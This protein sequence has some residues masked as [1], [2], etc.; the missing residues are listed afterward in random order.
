MGGPKVHEF[1][2]ERPRCVTPAGDLLAAGLHANQPDARVC[3]E[4]IEDAH[5]VAAAANAGDDCLR[6]PPRSFEDLPARLAPDDRLEVA[7]HQRIGMG[8]KRRSQQIV[9]A[10]HVG[11]PVAHRLVDGVLQRAAARIDANHLGAEEPHADNVQCLAGHVVDAHVDVAF[12]P[13]QRARRC[14]RDAVLPRAR[15]RDDSLLAHADGQQRLT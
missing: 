4:R 6:Q 5:R 13:E 7:N 12:E 8:P 2:T 14:G 11:H 10:G 3:H 9:R 15:F 1:M